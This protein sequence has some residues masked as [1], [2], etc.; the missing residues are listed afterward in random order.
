[1]RLAAVLVFLV[2]A[3]V[4]EYAFKQRLDHDITVRRQAPSIFGWLTLW[5]VLGLLSWLYVRAKYPVVQ[6]DQS[7]R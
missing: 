1:M 3:A 6:P 4:V 7:P 5:P 2:A